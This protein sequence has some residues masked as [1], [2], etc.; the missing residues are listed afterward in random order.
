MADVLA[1][2]QVT[3][4]LDEFF[5]RSLPIS[6][7]LNMRSYRYTGDS[8][9]LAID[10]APSINDKL[11]AFGGS[12]YCVSVMNC[13]GMVYLQ[14]RQRGINPNLVVS[15]AE[16]EYLLPVDDEIIVANCQQAG[17]TDWDIVF[18]AVNN[19]SKARVKLNSSIYCKGR[20]AVRFKGEYVVIGVNE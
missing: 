5:A 7:Y 16:I 13:W 19:G 20:E 2:D 12:L 3:H 17:N 9:S 14:G 15:G 10:L 6:Q 1:A 11:T 4:L 8:F 18:D